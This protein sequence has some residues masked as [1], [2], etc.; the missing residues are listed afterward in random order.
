MRGP[1]V[2][3]GYWQADDAT[4]AAKVDG[5]LRTGDLGRIDEEGNIYLTGRSKYIIVLDSGEKV[6]PDELE[7]CYGE[8]PLIQDIC[9]VPSVKRKAQVAAII[10]PNVDAIKARL[11][12]RGQAPGEATVRS[13]VQ[14]ELDT[15]AQQL[16]PHKRIAELMLADTPLP[17]TALQDVARGQVKDSYSFDVKRWLESAAGGILPAPPA[18][19]PAAE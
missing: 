13:A 17:K 2:F 5:W 15:L 18:E 6:H 16:A 7:E 1:N 9:V 8:S 12:E 3:A 10:Y 4:A 19:E 14:E 11:E